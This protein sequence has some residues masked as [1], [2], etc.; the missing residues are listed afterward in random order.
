[1]P[2]AAC[3][4]SES[5]KKMLPWQLSPPC[6]AEDS[7]KL[8]AVQGPSFSLPVYSLN[9]NGDPFLYHSSYICH[10][11]NGLGERR[12]QS[13]STKA[14]LSSWPSQWSLWMREVSPCQ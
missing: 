8:R 1:M 9:L 7:W 13:S 2:V 14:Q 3:L 11:G 10:A 4:L 12:T 5:E 6:W